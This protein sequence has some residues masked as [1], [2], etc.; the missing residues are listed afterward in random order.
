MPIETYGIPYTLRVDLKIRAVRLDAGDRCKG[1]G[2]FADI[3]W[4]SH[5]HIQQA[6]GTKSNEFPAVVFF[7]GINIRH[8]RRLPRLIQPVFNVV[9]T[10]DAI[11]CRDV[12]RP[13]LESDAYRGSKSHGKGFDLALSSGFSYGIDL[14][15]RRRA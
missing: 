13:I 8:D 11:D 12:Q 14:A 1:F 6:I 10:Q 9:K 5:C 2:R 7:A 3:A 4:R 15:F